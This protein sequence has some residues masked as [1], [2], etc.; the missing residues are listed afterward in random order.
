MAHLKKLDQ[1]TESRNSG[2][3]G[4]VLY[5]QPRAF[6]TAENKLDFFRAVVVVKWSAC[7]PF[8]LMI[9]LRIPLLSTIILQNCI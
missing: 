3:G 2:G 8:T 7:L 9:R 1:M 5:L 4:R 6:N